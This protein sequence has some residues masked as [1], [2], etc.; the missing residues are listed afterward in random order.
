MSAASIAEPVFLRAEHL[1]RSINGKILVEDANFEL[2][3]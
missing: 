1:G 2:K 3:K